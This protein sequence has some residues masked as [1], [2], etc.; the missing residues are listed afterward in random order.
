MKKLTLFFLFFC[1]FQIQAQVGVDDAVRVAKELSKEIKNK[2]F[3]PKWI[4]TA[5]AG[6]SLPSDITLSYGSVFNNEAEYQ[7]Y[8]ELIRN[9]SKLPSKLSYNINYSINY[10]ILRR[11][12]L[13]AVAEYQFQTQA[14]LSTWHIGPVLRYYFKSYEGPN[15]YAST[16][17]NVALA[18]KITSGMGN[19]RLGL[20][21]PVQKYIDKNLTLTIFWY[22]NTYKLSR[23]QLQSFEID[24][25]YIFKGYGINIGYQF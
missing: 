25:D 15:I 12:T 10:P 14:S 7:R 2:N 17:Y 20:Q 9:E 8:K 1:L 19:V 6:I 23:S 16:S 18:K 24:G 4:Q 5:E 22:T 11:L 3:Q 21:F 13:G